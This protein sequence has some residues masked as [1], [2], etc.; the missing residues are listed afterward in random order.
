LAQQLSVLTLAYVRRTISLLKE[1]QSRTRHDSTSSSFP[2]PSLALALHRCPSQ[3][4]FGAEEIATGNFPFPPRNVQ[5]NHIPP[6]ILG[7]S[8]S[9]SRF[10][11][12]STFVLAS[13]SLV[14]SPP[15]STIQYRDNVNFAD[16]ISNNDCNV[17]LFRHEFC[18]TV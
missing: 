16:T 8:S 9:L 1:Y 12:M 2:P 13:P 6:P 17:F 10:K 11:S 15:L 3:Q 4:G 5:W 18:S 7:P 14:P